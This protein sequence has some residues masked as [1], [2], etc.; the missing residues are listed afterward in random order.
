MRSLRAVA[1]KPLSERWPREELQD[2]RATPWAWNTPRE[3]AAEGVKVIPHVPAAAGAI[4][5]SPEPRGQVAPMRVN[6]AS[7]MLEEHG[8]TAGCRRHTLLRAGRTAAWGQAH[9]TVPGPH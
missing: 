1:R 7:A 3:A 5:V 9:G 2:P 8:Y 4:P 6:I